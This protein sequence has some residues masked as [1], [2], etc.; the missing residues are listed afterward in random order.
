ML[1]PRAAVA[2]VLLVLP[3][4]WE[5]EDIPLAV[6]EEQR[7]MGE[8]QRTWLPLELVEEGLL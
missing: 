3:S 1:G 8:G 7:E 4:C 2:E 5:T 6:R